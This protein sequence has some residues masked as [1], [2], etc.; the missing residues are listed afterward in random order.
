M[1]LTDKLIEK[2][3][4]PETK[5]YILRYFW[6]ISLMMLVLGYSIMAYILYYG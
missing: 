3:N 1:P 2:L 6:I 5:A 4:K